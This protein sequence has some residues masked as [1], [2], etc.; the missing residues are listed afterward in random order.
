[1]LTPIL[2][3]GTQCQILDKRICYEVYDIPTFS[4]STTGE[5]SCFGHPSICR[6]CQFSPKVTGS[7][8]CGT[9]ARND[10]KL[11]YPELFV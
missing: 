10:I 11:N 4:V 6:T 9:I 5:I 7:V 2:V 1:M 8:G 3:K